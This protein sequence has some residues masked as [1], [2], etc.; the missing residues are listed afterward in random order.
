MGK[1]AGSARP[2][3]FQ[4]DGL[5]AA[6]VAAAAGFAE[7]CLQFAETDTVN[8]SGEYKFSARWTKVMGTAEWKASRTRRWFKGLKPTVILLS[9]GIS[10]AESSWRAGQGWQRK[11][12]LRS[13]V[14]ARTKPPPSECDKLEGGR[15]ATHNFCHVSEHLPN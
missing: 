11:G 2:K 5:S 6:G 14:W 4:C 1:Q 9:R 13:V 8:Q 3:E 15:W 12:R 10:D 7:I